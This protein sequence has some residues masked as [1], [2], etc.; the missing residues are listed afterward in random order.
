MV[1]MGGLIIGIIV[2]ILIDILEV[3]RNIISEHN[4]QFTTLKSEISDLK[5]EVSTLN[6]EVST[7]N[8]EVSN[9]NTEVSN[10]NGQV[11]RLTPP[12]LGNFTLSLSG[13]FT[14][15]LNVNYILY[16][17]YVILQ[18]NLQSEVTA[19]LNVVL[20]GTLPS[21]LIPTSSS[22][23][24]IPVI[25]NDNAMDGLVQILP[26]GDI[27]FYPT[28]NGGYFTGTSNINETTI[29]YLLQ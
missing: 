5:S 2:K 18:W 23:Q 25:S 28:P 11:A 13:P 19:T 29:Q 17:S 12:I 1:K 8:T 20:T 14:L 22:T 7:L 4:E 3:I 6:T 16:P 24:I 9:L 27:N 21:Q 15:N 10:L 26:S